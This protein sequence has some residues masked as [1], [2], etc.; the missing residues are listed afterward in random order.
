MK[1]RTKRSAMLGVV[2]LGFGAWMTAACGSSEPSETGSVGPG[3]DPPDPLAE[4]SLAYSVQE[5]PSW[6][7]LG[8]EFKQK[9][10]RHL[11]EAQH[12]FLK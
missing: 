4:V 11:G 9:R 10:R 6:L 12:L 2:V 1:T 7:R 3:V 8:H 5:R